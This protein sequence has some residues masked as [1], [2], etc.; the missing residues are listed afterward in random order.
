LYA[1]GTGGGPHIRVYDGATGALDREWMAYDPE[2]RGGAWVAVGD[3]GVTHRTSIFQT[4]DGRADIVTGAGPGGGP[5]VRAF[6]GTDGAKL[7]DYFA[8]DR[9]L[10]GGVTVAVGDVMGGVIGSSGGDGLPDIV[11]GA[12]PGGPPLVTVVPNFP[13]GVG[14]PSATPPMIVAFDEDFRGGVLVG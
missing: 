7:T 10:R 9:D 8:F 4:I 11:C 14:A 1:T 3:V 5:H 13:V 6:S 2:F 12:G